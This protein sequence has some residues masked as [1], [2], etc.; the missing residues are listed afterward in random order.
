METITKKKSKMEKRGLICD[1]YNLIY[2]KYLN[3]LNCIIVIVL[4]MIDL[5]ITKC[6]DHDIIL[7]YL[8]IFYV[9]LVIDN[10]IILI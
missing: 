7:V 1:D 2:E 6:M 10:N 8:G 4:T 5:N 3:T 9:I